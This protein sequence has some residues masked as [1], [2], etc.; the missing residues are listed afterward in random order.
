MALNPAGKYLFIN[1]SH[2]SFLKLNFGPLESWFSKLKQKRRPNITRIDI[3][4]ND[5]WHNN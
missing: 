3:Q 2:V 5:T 4:H 1:F